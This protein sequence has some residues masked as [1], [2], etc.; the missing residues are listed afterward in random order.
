MSE[1][2]LIELRHVALN[3]GVAVK[4]IC[5]FVAEGRLGPSI[6]GKPKRG[7]PPTLLQRKLVEKFF[8]KELP[9]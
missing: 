3:T 8:H 4:T 9:L 7:R 6:V 5:R 2:D 1:P